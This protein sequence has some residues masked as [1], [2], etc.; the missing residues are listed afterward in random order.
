MARS[1]AFRRSASE[2]V[3]AARFVEVFGAV[4]VDSSIIWRIAEAVVHHLPKTFRQ[5]SLPANRARCIVARLY[6]DFLA[7][8]ARGLYAVSSPTTSSS[9]GSFV[10]IKG[11]TPKG[12]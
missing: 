9:E 8:A 11:G 7:M 1:A 10:S 12:F 3:S 2:R 5:L 6:P 4:A